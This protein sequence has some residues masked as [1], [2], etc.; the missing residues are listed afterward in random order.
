M[1]GGKIVQCYH[2]RSRLQL[3]CHIRLRDITT[4]PVYVS[5][6]TA[7]CDLQK[8]FTFDNK[9]S[10]T[11]RVYKPRVLVCAGGVDCDSWRVGGG[12]GTGAVAAD[13]SQ[14][15][16]VVVDKH[17]AALDRPVHRRRRDGP[18]LTLLQRPLQGRRAARQGPLSRRPSPTCH[19]LQP[20]ARHQIR[21]PSPHGQGNAD[22][23]VLSYH[24][25][26]HF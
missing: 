6:V 12:F 18:G 17:S 10:I 22:Q 8:S 19:T 11:S 23:P 3:S 2:R 20:R 24:Q 5:N 26:Q 16:G 25:Q 13:Q 7:S 21:V 14:Q 9:V 4:F 15:Q 1:D